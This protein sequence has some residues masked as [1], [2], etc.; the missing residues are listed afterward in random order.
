MNL[1]FS[2]VVSTSTITAGD[3]RVYRFGDGTDLASATTSDIVEMITPTAAQLTLTQD[4]SLDRETSIDLAF[5]GVPYVSTDT[6]GYLVSFINDGDIAGG[7]YNGDDL[8]GASYPYPNQVSGDECVG[9]S[10][11]AVQPFSTAR[12]F[13]IS[14]FLYGAF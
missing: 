10:A 8:L 1:F 5:S 7:C 2:E 9:T 12:R 3:F 14:V 4:S 6:A 13:N 11:A